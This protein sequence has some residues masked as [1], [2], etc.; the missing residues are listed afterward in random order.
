MQRRKQKI[1]LLVSCGLVSLANLQAQQ[2]PQDSTKTK[3]IQEVVV[4][5]LGIKRE[6]K[7]L[8]YVAE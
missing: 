1:I 3:D 6:D 4:T 5:A 8:G 7:S 2:K